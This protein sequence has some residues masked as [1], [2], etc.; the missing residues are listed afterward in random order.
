[1]TV[2]QR[3]AFAET[4]S[5]RRRGDAG[6][7]TPDHHQVVS[8]QIVRHCVSSCVHRIEYIGGG[9]VP[10]LSR[11]ISVIDSESNPTNSESY[12]FLLREFWVLG[13]RAHPY[14]QNDRIRRR[15]NSKP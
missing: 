8:F 15:E 5:F 11:S 3:D 6:G 4:R 12:L 1:M 14:T 10:G 13:D 2:H 9:N 7:T